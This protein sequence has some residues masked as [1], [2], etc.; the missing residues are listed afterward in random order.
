MI[1]PN[2][3]EIAAMEAASNAAGEYI[4]SLRQTDMAQWSGEQ[5]KAFIGVVCGGY[6]DSLCQQ[7]AMINEALNKARVE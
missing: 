7:Q 2:E 1:D 5:W 3:Y 6:T 4:E